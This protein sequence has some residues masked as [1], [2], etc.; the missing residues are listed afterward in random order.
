MAIPEGL[1]DPQVELLSRDL[2]NIAVLVGYPVLLKL[3]GGGTR[4]VRTRSQ[5]FMTLHGLAEVLIEGLDR[6]VSVGSILVTKETI[7]AARAA[8]DR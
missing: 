4:E 3:D 5:A 2:F 8:N 6:P 1:Y 7:D